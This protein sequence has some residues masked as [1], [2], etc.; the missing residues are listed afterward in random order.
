[1]PP[2]V[3]PNFQCKNSEK[4]NMTI[5]GGDSSQKISHSPPIPVGNKPG[6]P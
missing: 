6:D 4:Q 2:M 1:M 3:N 5:L